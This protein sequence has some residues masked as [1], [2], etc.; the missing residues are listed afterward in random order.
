M[1][2]T[3]DLSLLSVIELNDIHSNNSKII[4]EV[5]WVKKNL[6]ILTVFVSITY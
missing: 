1:P 3:L 6:T 4:K 5:C 2:V